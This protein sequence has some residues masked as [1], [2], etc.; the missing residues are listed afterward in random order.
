MSQAITTSRPYAQAA[1]EEAVMLGDLKSWSEMLCKIADY[2]ADSQLK[3]V[4]TS[5]KVDSYQ[6]QLLMLDLAGS[7]ISVQAQNFIKILV[8][9]NRLDLL[10]EIL[11]HFEA[12]RADAEK[13]IDVEV[14][15]AYEMSEDQKRKVIAALKVKMGCEINLSSAIDRALLGGIVIRAGDK[16]IDGSARA[17]LS[18]LAVALA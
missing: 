3:A 1:F 11:K 10:P 12:F 18:E 2:T 5:P 6:L 4:I 9:N 16:V 14:T 7:N 8:A 13:S 15:S 17:R